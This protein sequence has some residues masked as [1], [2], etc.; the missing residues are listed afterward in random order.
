MPY[1]LLL[2][3]DTCYR[4]CAQASW[5][6][7]S[8]PATDFA[9]VC[10]RQRGVHPTPLPAAHWQGSPG[11]RDVRCALVCVATCSA[12]AAMMQLRQT[13]PLSSV[14]EPGAYKCIFLAGGQGAMGDMPT[15]SDLPRVVGGA[16]KL[17]RCRLGEALSAPRTDSHS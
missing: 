11:T 16:A 15:N 6:K 17:G 14:K 2:G 3:G 8:L 7:G 1:V 13:V 10:T 9:T 12:E 5:L 4:E